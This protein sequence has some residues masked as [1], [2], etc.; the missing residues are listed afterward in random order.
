M[1]IYQSFRAKNRCNGNLKFVRL[2]LQGPAARVDSLY[3]LGVCS[4]FF[5]TAL[6]FLATRSAWKTDT[7][8]TWG[9]LAIRQPA[10]ESVA[11]WHG[12]IDK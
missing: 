6:V 9:V 1:V 10:G 5:V 3:R 8:R 4:A 11:K 7:L 12:A 2:R